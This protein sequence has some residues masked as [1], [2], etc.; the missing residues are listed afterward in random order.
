MNGP[1]DHVCGINGITYMSAC[2]AVYCGGLAPSDF[3]Q[4]NCQNVVS[5]FLC[6]YIH[7]HVH[8]Y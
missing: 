7:L 1:A 3:Y 2:A 4:G 8:Y 5:D 6:V